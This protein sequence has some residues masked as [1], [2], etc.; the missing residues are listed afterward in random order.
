MFKLETIWNGVVQSNSDLVEV[1]LD[2][3]T[4]I[5]STARRADKGN[6]KIYTA[7]DFSGS[8]RWS[9]VLAQ[10]INMVEPGVR[11]ALAN[12]IIDYL[13]LNENDLRDL[14]ID[15]VFRTYA[16]SNIE[17]AKGT[18]AS[19]GNSWHNFSCAIDV[20]IYVYKNDRWVW[21][22]GKTKTSL[23]EYTVRLRRSMDKFKIHNDIAGDSGHFYPM[24]FP[25][26]PPVNLKIGV[27][28]I[29]DFIA[30]HNGGRSY[31]EPPLLRSLIPRIR[32]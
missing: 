28:S 1:T 15:T 31:V 11:E 26:T 4:D 27:W 21:Q 23:E 16:E 2:T 32:P 24:G 25:K 18:G 6:G 10:K 14:K 29:E 17:A 3:V 20:Q 12:G 8:A 7:A 9:S 22:T 30:K 19:G 5:I 13:T